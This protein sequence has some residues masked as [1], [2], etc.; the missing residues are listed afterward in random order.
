MPSTL[1]GQ[2]EQECIQPMSSL[3]S[4]VTSQG[5]NAAVF[6]GTSLS[7]DRLISPVGNLTLSNHNMSGVLVLLAP[8]IGSIWA[9][10]LL[11]DASL[12]KPC[13]CNCGHQSRRKTCMAALSS[14][15]E[16]CQRHANR[17]LDVATILRKTKCF[18]S[19]AGSPT[20]S[21][22]RPLVP[23]GVCPGPMTQ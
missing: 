1:A 10:A 17:Q 14:A 3:I 22:H 5:C 9:F 16:C 13:S 4:D 12:N 2:E 6:V 23:S 21:T 19:N 18:F 7:L 11:R 15:L 8:K 20:A